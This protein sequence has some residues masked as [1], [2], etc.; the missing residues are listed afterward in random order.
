[1]SDPSSIS[2]ENL[3]KLYALQNSLNIQNSNT[4]TIPLPTN[5]VYAPSKDF[6]KTRQTQQ[7]PTPMGVLPGKSSADLRSPEDIA[8]DKML[9]M[10]K[11]DNP[12]I[13]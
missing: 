12:F 13:Q 2:M 4:Q 6:L 1:M 3:W 7:V 8:M 11:R 10:E 9:E 5:Q